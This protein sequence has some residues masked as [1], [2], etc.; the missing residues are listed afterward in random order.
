[1]DQP[2][3]FSINHTYS[4]LEGFP[5]AILFSTRI[6]AK[7]LVPF[8]TE[9][10]SQMPN[11]KPKVFQPVIVLAFYGSFKSIFGEVE[12]AVNLCMTYKGSMEH[13]P[14]LKN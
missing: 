13:K 1:M 7:T 11:L 12:T 10:K 8:F 4:N 2:I 9:S 14:K 3:W 6:A 5:V